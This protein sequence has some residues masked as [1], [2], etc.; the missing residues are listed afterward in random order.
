VNLEAF[1]ANGMAAQKAVAELLRH[2]LGAPDAVKL[3]AA[4]IL[5]GAGVTRKRRYP[6]SSARGAG[7][8]RLKRNA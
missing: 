6:G 7:A 8:R 1:A 2:N 3:P 4:E 5:P